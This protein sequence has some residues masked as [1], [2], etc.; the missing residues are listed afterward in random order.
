M[1]EEYRD[2]RDAREALR[3]CGEAMQMEDSEFDEAYPAVTFKQWLIERGGER[4]AY[5]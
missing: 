2:A 5:A 1:V 4:S 3:E